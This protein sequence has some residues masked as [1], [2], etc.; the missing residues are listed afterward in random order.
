M[1]PLKPRF[2][3]IKKFI[4]DGNYNVNVSWSFLDNFLTEWKSQGLDMDPDFQR[5]HVWS[6]EK[7]VA[8]VE[9]ILQGGRSSRTILFNNP[10]WNVTVK[11]DDDFVL[12]DGKQRLEAVRRFLHDEIPAFWHMRSEYVDKLPA[13]CGPDFVFHVNTLQTREEVL[14]WY[15]Q[16]NSG[17]VVHTEEEL[18]KV[19]G[20]LEEAK[21]P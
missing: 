4:P 10:N 20:L 21:K 5:G 9:F 8:Y 14:L 18:N 2:R 16:L 3:D 12:V 7:Q 11:P 1:D 17:G 13:M 6:E 15:L 19:R